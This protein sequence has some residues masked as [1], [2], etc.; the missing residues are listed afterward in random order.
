MVRKGMNSVMEP[1][2]EPRR[3]TIVLTMLATVLAGILGVI[4][5][6]VETGPIVR[7]TETAKRASCGDLNARAK[8]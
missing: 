1:I 7:L 4:I 3:V 6:Q 8:P 5:A 2:Q